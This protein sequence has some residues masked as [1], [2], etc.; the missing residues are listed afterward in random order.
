L[1]YKLKNAEQDLRD[2]SL[3]IETKLL[4]LRNT[5]HVKKIM[6]EH[7]RQQLSQTRQEWAEAYDQ[8]VELDKRKKDELEKKFADIENIRKNIDRIEASVKNR[9]RRLDLEEETD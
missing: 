3:E 9:V 2:F 5:I 1:R 7:L 8:H 4:N 6:Y